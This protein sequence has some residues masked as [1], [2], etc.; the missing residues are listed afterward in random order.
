M[1]GKCGKCSKIDLVPGMNNAIANDLK[2]ALC[3]D[4]DNLMFEP[5]AIVMSPEFHKALEKPSGIRGISIVV[6]ELAEKHWDL[7]F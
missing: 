2:A 4:L 7:K 1:C 6:N 3:F 5:Q